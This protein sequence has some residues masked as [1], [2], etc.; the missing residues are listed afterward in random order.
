M[1]LSPGMRGLIRKQ[2]WLNAYWIPL[3]FQ[4]VALMAIAVPAALLRLDGRHHVLAFA[5]AATIAAIISM[6]VPPAFGSLSD[7]L[8][9][10]GLSR[11]YTIYA[12][13]IV[14]TLGLLLMII[15][16]SWVALDVGFF[17]SAFG[18]Q[19]SVTG[20]QALIPEVVPR[21]NWGVAAGVRGA[22]TLIGT[23]IA[24]AVSSLISPTFVF[25]AAAILS[26]LGVF[27]IIPIREKRYA[28][29][30]EALREAKERVTISDWHDF[31]VVFI[32]R[33]FT[34]FGMSLLMTYV[35]YFFKDVLH[36]AHPSTGTAL[37]AGIALIGS[38]VSSVYAGRLSDRF[39]RKGLVALSAIPM[40]LCTAVFAALPILWIVIPFALFF[41]LGYG[42]FL[43]TDWALGIDSVP[44]LRDVARDLGIW[45][46][47]AGLPAVL[48]PAFGGWLLTHYG[49]QLAGYR[50]M[51]AI[52]SA[53]FVLGA[54][55]VLQVR[56]DSRRLRERS[57]A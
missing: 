40:A 5:E 11:N 50:W 36:Q 30:A 22:A 31:I 41:G 47:A 44:Q 12:G 29:S 7:T 18:H 55:T 13:A 10:R 46:I 53:S 6:V 49:D 48:A 23:A 43:A 45:G 17:I 51:F 26:S 38:I 4:Q 20:Y 35:L 33:S 1:K 54:I 56:R 28:Q 3:N 21:A 34:L 25:L 24:L 57:A 15:A 32:S 8:W 52:A 14:N 27:T 9:R 42:A 19:L 39:T 16:N 2:S 37:V